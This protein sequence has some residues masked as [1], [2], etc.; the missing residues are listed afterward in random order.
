L[1]TQK[2]CKKPLSKVK[3]L[4]KSD[5]ERKNEIASALS[6]FQGS[7]G[8]I[9]KNKNVNIKTKSGFSI[10]YNYA[11]L[12]DI[13]R[14]IRKPLSENG[15]SVSHSLQAKDND[16]ILVTTIFHISGQ[17]LRSFLPIGPTADEKT[18]GSKITYFRRY[19]LS[20]L[21]GI[22]T[23]DDVDA[24]LQGGTPSESSSEKDHKKK[25]DVLSCEAALFYKEHETLPF[26]HEFVSFVAEK[27]RS[28]RNEILEEAVKRKKEFLEALKDYGKKKGSKE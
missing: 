7:V 27:S 14:T 22:V 26:F 20:S 9:E 28:H 18:L 3:R 19:S 5:L 15:L 25:E 13:M 8:A 10:K 23:D 21:L 24:D 16:R 12:A 6:K 11:D 2:C 17:W 1:I 4:R